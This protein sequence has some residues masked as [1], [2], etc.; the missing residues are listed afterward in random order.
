MADTK[1]MDAVLSLV[2]RLQLFV[3]DE[4]EPRSVETLEA[5]LTEL[6]SWLVTVERA[7]ARWRASRQN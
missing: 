6:Y 4:V 3:D 1:A 7:G 2:A 5:D